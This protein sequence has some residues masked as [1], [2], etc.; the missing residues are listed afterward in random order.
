M[1]E[2]GKEGA[3]LSSGTPYTYACMLVWGRGSIEC[4]YTVHICM[5]ASVGQGLN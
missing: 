3:Q 1:D 2:S 4:R 5:Q